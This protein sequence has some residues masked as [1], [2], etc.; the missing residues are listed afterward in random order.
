M[1]QQP[2]RAFVGAREDPAAVLFAGNQQPARGRSIFATQY[3]LDKKWALLYFLAN[4]RDALPIWYRIY[5]DDTILEQLLSQVEGVAYIADLGLSLNQ[6]QEIFPRSQALALMT[7]SRRST[8]A[9]TAAACVANALNTIVSDPWGWG[10]DAT[11]YCRQAIR[12]STPSAVVYRINQDIEDLLEKQ[13]QNLADAIRQNLS[14]AEA[15]AHHEGYPALTDEFPH[16]VLWATLIREQV[17]QV[18]SSAQDLARRRARPDAMVLERLN[19]VASD[20]LETTEAHLYTEA[21]ATVLPYKGPMR[22]LTPFIAAIELRKSPGLFLNMLPT[23][24]GGRVGEIV[25]ASED[26]ATIV[27][28]AWPDD[29][30]ATSIFDILDRKHVIWLG[31][32]C[33]DDAMKV[34]A[35]RKPDS[36]VVPQ[37]I[38][39]LRVLAE[40]EDQIVYFEQVKPIAETVDYLRRQLFNRPTAVSNLDTAHLMIV[41]A[42]SELLRQSLWTGIFDT[43]QACGQAI[44]YGSLGEVTRRRQR[45]HLAEAIRRNL[46]EAQQTAHDFGFPDLTGTERDV[47]MATLVR[48][49][50]R[51]MLAAVA[52]RRIPFPLLEDR[53]NE[54]TSDLSEV[55]EAEAYLAATKQRSSGW[56]TP[57]ESAVYYRQ[58]CDSFRDDLE[59]AKSGRVGGYLLGEPASVGAKKGFAK[60]WNRAAPRLGQEVRT[61]CPLSEEAAQCRNWNARLPEIGVVAWVSE[62]RL[63]LEGNPRPFTRRQSGAWVLEGYTTSNGPYLEPI[64]A[65][66]GGIVSD[67]WNARKPNTATPRFDAQSILDRATG[68]TDRYYDPTPEI[69]DD[70]DYHEVYHG[71]KVR[72]LGSPGYMMKVPASRV[73]PMTENSWYP[74]QLARY[75]KAI[76]DGDLLEPPAARVHVIDED[77]IAMTQEMVDDGEL[78]EPFDE[79]DL[80][81]PYVMLADGNHRG[82]AALLSGE[83]YLWVYV[84]ERY[85]DEARP[86]M[87]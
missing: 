29:V 11:V 55:T 84:G 50:T 75:M 86:W 56:R 14:E 10:D 77:A 57:F 49:Q 36:T 27:L 41:V 83:P 24:T 43:L 46:A 45:K 40:E 62:N 79:D 18:L 47:L 51:Q 73:L 13:S 6:L 37:A 42:L 25:G 53:F 30:L 68:T 8:N 69:P 59:N 35:Y 63:F 52:R 33:L 71:R 12:Y 85:R 70:D 22:T 66:V 5:P 80:G 65:K 58:A 1:R 15:I 64:D 17:R 16:N 7:N 39:A 19:E 34:Y 26:P 21:C 3:C 2:R 60:P 87:E 23:A 82:F 54:A 74:N 81:E 28:S 44:R 67:A 4:I 32:A 61:V 72:W 38:A 48:E 9:E 76:E 31:L 20:L 78:E